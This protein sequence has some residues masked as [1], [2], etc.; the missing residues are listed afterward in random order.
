MKEI[1]ALPR[2]TRLIV[3]ANYAS[4]LMMVGAL[5]IPEETDEVHLTFAGMIGNLP[6]YIDPYRD[7]DGVELKFE[8]EL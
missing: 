3:S 1:E 2:N 4:L 5:Q 7:Q 6:V 8:G